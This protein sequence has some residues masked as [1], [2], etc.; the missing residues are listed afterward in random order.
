MPVDDVEVPGNATADPGSPDTSAAA[1]ATAD[2]QNGAAPQ[3]TEDSAQ[4]TAQPARNAAD[5]RPGRTSSSTNPNA[6]PQNTQN[7][8]G[9][10]AKSSTPDELTWQQRYSYLQSETAKKLSQME[11]SRRQE[12][13]EMADLR[14]FRQQ[15]QQ[16]AEALKLK[17]W[18]KQHPDH[19]KFQD[20]LGRAKTVRQ[21]LNAIDPKLPPEQQEILKQAITSA[22]A[23]E[24]QQTLQEYQQSVADFQKD[25]FIDPRGTIQPMMREA[26]QEAFN[27]YRMHQEA[28][29]AVDRDFAAMKDAIAQHGPELKAMLERGTPYDVAVENVKLKASLGALQNRVGQ[30]EKVG[31]AAAEQQRLAK[32]NA[33][34]TRDPAPNSKPNLYEM[35][36]KQ[37]KEQGIAT[38][39]PRFVRILSKLEQNLLK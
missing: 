17:S 34:I 21:Q 2:T 13:Q 33:A 36:K 14:N 24:E 26:I 11:A 5:T 19:S 7:T 18:S 32:G 22:I 31:A 3:N 1:P 10:R 29:S 37:A 12:T 16:Q 39:D 8:P 23:P 30:V 15:Q 6:I 9:D 38:D 27:Q 35:A 25:F 20:L 4:G 28:S